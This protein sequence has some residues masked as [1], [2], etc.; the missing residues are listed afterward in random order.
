[1][2]KPSQ[3]NTFIGYFQQGRKQKPFRGLSTLLP[4]ASI[5]A[6]DS[7]SRMGKGEWQRV[8]SNRAFFDVNVG[9]FYL[10]WPMVPATDP[11]TN[12]P[13]QFRGNA[14]RDGAGWLAFSTVRQK[15]QVKAQM[16]YYMPD[17]A[18]S[19]DFKFG[20]ESIY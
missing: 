13:L 17:K 6:Q 9:S 19:H 20:F 15:P 5:L 11:T 2:W 7:Y 1:T 10:G 18:G 16:T 14:G 4:P 3:G 12:P 8:L